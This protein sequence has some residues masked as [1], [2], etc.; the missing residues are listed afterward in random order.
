MKRT[1][2]VLTSIG[3]VVFAALYLYIKS[4]EWMVKGGLYYLKKTNYAPILE[5]DSFKLDND[6]RFILE[7]ILKGMKYDVYQTR[8]EEDSAFVLVNFE[9][10]D[11][12]KLMIDESGT[13]LK[14]TLSDWRGVLDDWANHRLQGTM[15]RQLA[16]LLKETKNRPTKQ[17]TVEIPFARSHLW[18]K[19]NLN[20]EWV[21]KV[22]KDYFNLE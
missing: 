21:E 12:S 18:W 4:P 6:Q 2:M 14:N 20:E 16:L 11:L 7:D 1:L 8:F 13:L 22:L 19:L 10:I 9:I 5:S 3:V 17:L 15:T